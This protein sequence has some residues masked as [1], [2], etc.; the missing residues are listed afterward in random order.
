MK[1]TNDGKG[2]TTMIKTG[3]KKMYRFD[4][5]TWQGWIEVRNVGGYEK[6]YR[7]YFQVHRLNIEDAKKDAQ[8]MAQ[9][10]QGVA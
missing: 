1:S 4:Q 6:L 9:N 3:A 5:P 10:I 8:R 7:E 2:A